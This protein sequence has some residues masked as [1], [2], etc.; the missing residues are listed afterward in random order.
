LKNLTLFYYTKIIPIRRIIVDMIKLYPKNLKIGEKFTWSTS[1][2]RS[3]ICRAN[4]I[5]NKRNRSMI[6]M[7]A[8]FINPSGFEKNEETF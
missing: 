2:S 6:K 7:S 5:V 1:L 3:E 4:I 8:I